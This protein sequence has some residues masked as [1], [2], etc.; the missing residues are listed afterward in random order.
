MKSPIAATAITA[1]VNQPPANN[2]RDIMNVPMILAL[3]ATRTITIKMG[4]AI[5]QLMTAAR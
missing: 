3:L 1:A 2:P 5:S 4:T